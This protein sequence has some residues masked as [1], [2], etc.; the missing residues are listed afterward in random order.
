MQIS[1]S[2]EK[3]AYLIMAHHRPDLLRNL[4]SALDEDGN[5]VYLHIDKNSLN[6]MS[7]YSFSMEHGHLTVIPSLSIKWGHPSQVECALNLLET[8]TRDGHHLYYHLLTG[9]TYPLKSQDEIRAFFSD[10]RGTEFIG[11]AERN[12]VERVKY[13]WLFKDAIGTSKDSKRKWEFRLHRL[14]D[15]FR[16]DLFKKYDMECK[17]GL[18][19]W[20][21]TDD[22][23]RYVLNQKKI[24]LEMTRHSSCGDEIFMQTIA[25]N[26]PFRD[27]LYLKDNLSEAC[28]LRLSTW[29]IEE[30][31][32]RPGH[33][34]MIK[35]LPLLL[36][37][38]SMFALKFEGPAGPHLIDILKNRIM[39][40][41]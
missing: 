10:Y 12:C 29:E 21:I 3:H 30:K 34:F 32:R 17:K 33:N 40:H 13:Y 16:I 19:Y 22:L 37:S 2:T 11:F 41:S 28:S 23:A 6:K 20:S 8:A 31:E 36:D 38:D 39:Q 24:I 18:A 7:P 5:D 1:K 9:A 35:D 14:Q 15:L 26:S 4:L 25:W 27:R